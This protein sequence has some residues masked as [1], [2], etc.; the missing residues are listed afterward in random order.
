[1]DERQA[2]YPSPGGDHAPTVRERFSE[3]DI[4]VVHAIA[5]NSLG[6]FAA[7][8]TSGP[9]PR[10]NDEILSSWTESVS[11]LKPAGDIYSLY[12]HGDTETVRIAVNIISASEGHL[13]LLGNL[14]LAGKMT[15]AKLTV[16]QRSREAGHLLLGVIA[17]FAYLAWTRPDV[18]RVFA[19]LVT[20]AY[21]QVDQT[22]VSLRAALVAVFAV[23]ITLVLIMSAYAALLRKPP[24]EAGREFLKLTLAFACGVVGGGLT[25]H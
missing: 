22:T 16:L 18:K 2:L 8:L 19:L 15:Y 20:P 23:A 17:W 4:R 3:A 1:M 13:A 10:S 9:L 6:V 12:D 25:P 5:E 7:R 14:A 11:S 21:A 24:L